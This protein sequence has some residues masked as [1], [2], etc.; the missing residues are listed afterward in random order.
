MST[1]EE[2][3]LGISNRNREAS[4]YESIEEMLDDYK[5]REP[6]LFSIG[7]SFGVNSP[8]FTLEVSNVYVSVE[9]LKDKEGNNSGKFVAVQGLGKMKIAKLF[10]ATASLIGEYET[11]FL[12]DP[13]EVFNKTKIPEEEEEDLKPK[14]AFH[15]MEHHDLLQDAS[16]TQG[17]YYLYDTNGDFREKQYALSVTGLINLSWLEKIGVNCKLMLG[18]GG[19]FNTFTDS[20]EVAVG[21]KFTTPSDK[22]WIVVGQVG[23]MGGKINTLYV[24]VRGEIPIGPIVFTQIK[25]GVTGMADTVQTYSPG[26]GVAFGPEISFGSLASPVAKVL[27]LKK[28]NFYVLEVG[29]SGDIASDFS[30]VNLS[31]EGTLLGLLEIKGGWKHTSAGYNEIGL[32]VGTSRSSTFNFTISGSVGWSS[33]QLTVNASLDGSFKWDFSVWGYTLIGVNVGGG[34]KVVY[35]EIDRRRNLSIS[36]NGRANVKIT[37]F[38]VGVNVSKNWNIDLGTR[39]GFLSANVPMEEA[40]RPVYTVSRELSLR[41]AGVAEIAEG[42]LLG[43][44]SWRADAFAAGGKM[45]ITVAAQ[46]SLAN[47]EWILTGADGTKYSSDNG[48]EFLSVEQVSYSQIEITIDKPAEG[49]WSLDVFG[50][51]KWNGEIF[52]GAEAG[53]P[54]ETELRVVALEGTSLTIEYR[55]HATGQDNFVALYME[56]ADKDDEDYEGTIVDYLA[57]TEGEEFQTVTL[58]LPED[59]QGDKF[60]F[61]VMA[62]SSNCDE[63]AYSAKTEAVELVRRTADLQLSNFT[64]SQLA[65]DLLTVTASLTLTNLGTV[66]ADDFTVEMFLGDSEINVMDDELLATSKVSLS[67]GESQDLSFT[68]AVPEEYRGEIAVL[69]I[70]I[71]RG[72]IVDEG[73]FEGNNVAVKTLSFLGDEQNGTLFS[74]NWD[75]VDGA[76]EYRLDYSIDRNDQNEVTLTGIQENGIDLQMTPGWYDFTITPIDAEGKVIEDGIQKWDD[77]VAFTAQYDLA[78]D[79]GE[80]FA[81][82]EEFTLYDGLYDWNGL[83]LGD[84]TG[85]L[86]L[87]LVDGKKEGVDKAVMKVSVSKGKAKLNSSQKDVL[88]ENGLYYFSAKSTKKTGA[89][90]LS[91]SFSLEGDVLPNEDASRNQLSLPDCVDEE[92]NFSE[93]LDG[94]V[95]ILASSDK[96]EYLLEDA[97]ELS[98][99]VNDLDDMTGNI[100]IDLYV[101]NSNNGKYSKQ[102]SFTV[103]PTTKNPQLLTDYIVTNNFYLEVRSA[104][105]GK[106]KHNSDYSINVDFQEFDD[107]PVEETILANEDKDID[108]TGWVGHGKS[109]DTYLLQLDGEDCGSYDFTINGDAGEASLKIC[110]I[111]GKTLKSVKIGK[112]GTAT[113]SDIN[114]YTGSYLVTVTCKSSSKSLYNTDYSLNI[115][116]NSAFELLSGENS[117]TVDSVAKKEECWFAL[118]AENSG[119]YDFHELLAAGLKVSLYEARTTG[120][121][122]S[123][124]M[125]SGLVELPAAEICYM[126][127]SNAKSAWGDVVFGLDEENR[128]VTMAS[129]AL[130]NV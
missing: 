80:K 98:I 72:E 102:K 109:S 127:I 69:S 27:G 89:D 6:D 36:V 37:F 26:L 8:A 45:V 71:D 32:S 55:A 22:E 38:T 65:T 40:Q 119:A 28:G 16:S 4:G 120:G 101:Q 63:V 51:K 86:T 17:L 111:S 60:R 39:R 79:A 18:V 62:Q 104:D 116:Q 24:E 123:L 34:I 99:S 87:N 33:N 113:I 11:Y 1:K 96:W 43:T 64:V 75:A 74:V 110:S 59:I 95:G 107:A 23:F 44:G 122:A 76:V 49:V 118:D 5:D 117:I 84:F 31:I 124:K 83:D 53:D 15:N 115:H 50:S 67:G 66:A 130:P 114:L 126:K 19:A 35:N 77:D 106:G 54:I 47:T 41:D 82:T 88:L 10:H 25:F 81:L 48:A 125:K 97:G 57:P 128:K 42:E 70:H 29:A 78:F 14:N 91:L 61:Y 12:T 100:V 9:Q 105:N 13:L 56:Q 85:T 3:S 112:N 121:L 90:G 92:G 58:E 93:T 68:V 46:Y 73:Y 52:I 103:K 20:W 7:G 108:V 30:D 2:T 129:L 21:A 94:W